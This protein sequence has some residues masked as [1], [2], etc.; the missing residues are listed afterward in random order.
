MKRTPSKILKAR[1]RPWRCSKL[2][3]LL[4]KEAFERELRR[5]FACTK[6]SG[7]PLT[8][9]TFSVEPGTDPRDKQVRRALDLAEHIICTRSRLSDIAGWY[10]THRQIG[11]LLCGTSL[12]DAR[13]PLEAIK[14]AFSEAVESQS[15]KVELRCQVLPFLALSPHEIVGMAGG[16]GCITDATPSGFA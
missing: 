4:P 8:L 7:S 15:L 6:R 1:K 10:G 11:V 16:S 12:D 13:Y 2:R 5:Q 14:G 9:V 3:S